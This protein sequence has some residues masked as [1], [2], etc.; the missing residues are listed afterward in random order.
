M[1]EHIEHCW[2]GGRLGHEGPHNT[3]QS[4]AELLQELRAAIECSG[5]DI[6]CCR[7][8]GEMVVSIPDGL[9]VCEV[10]AEREAAEQ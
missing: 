3:H 10:C 2:C 7:I 8:C 1:S 4:H 6:T 5:L 9:P